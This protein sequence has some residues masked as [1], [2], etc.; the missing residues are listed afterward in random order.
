MG[1]LL[2]RTRRSP[3]LASG[4]RTGSIRY[5]DAVRRGRGAWWHAARQQRRR[6]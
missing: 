4:G 1:L 6:S 5:A 2:L 3:D